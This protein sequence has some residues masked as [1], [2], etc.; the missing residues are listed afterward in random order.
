MTLVGMS[1][2][3]ILSLL[4]VICSVGGISLKAA[5][6]FTANFVYNFG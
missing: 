6:E 1:I 5:L 3:L 2:W 4:L